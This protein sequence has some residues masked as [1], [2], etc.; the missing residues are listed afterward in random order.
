MRRRVAEEN[1]ILSDNE[2]CLHA[3]LDEWL[4]THDAVYRKSVDIARR[5]KELHTDII[6]LTGLLIDMRSRLG[7]AASE[8]AVS[9]DHRTH[10]LS[11]VSHAAL[12]T[13]L[14][15]FGHLQNEQE[16][17][18]AKIAALNAFLDGTIYRELK[19]CAYRPVV[20][21]DCRHGMDYPT[22]HA[23]FE[24]GLAEVTRTIEHLAEDFPT[25]DPASAMLENI[26]FRYRDNL[27][28]QYLGELNGGP[29]SLAG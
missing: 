19:L 29:E 8:L 5:L 17:F 23:N 1:K 12:D 2:Q 4:T 6:T 28:K 20:A 27:W 26:L 22:L 13:L 10:T 14:H 21:P 18:I 7:A 25:A 11:D 24:K 16:K 9:F 3:S 15:A